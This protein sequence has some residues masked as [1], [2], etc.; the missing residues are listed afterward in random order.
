MKYKMIACDFD[1]TLSDS[2]SF[3]SEKNRQA[4]AEYVARGGKFVLSTGRMISAIIPHAKYLGLKGEVIGYQ[5]AVIADIE[6]GKFYNE[7]TIPYESA[8]KVARKLD[9]EG[10]YYQI[11][12]HDDYVI[13]AET[14][15]AEEYAKYTFEPPVIAGMPL[16][17]YIEKNGISPVKMLIITPPEKV[18]GYIDELSAEYGDEFLINTSK[19]FV[20]EIIRG[21]VNKA[22]AVAALAS[23]YGIKREEII[24]IGDSLN[25]V[26][27]VKYAGLGVMV[28]NA[29]DKAL[30]VADYVAPSCD[31]DGVA[32]VIE[33]IALKE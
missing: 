26:P 24:A 22:K 30:A 32:Y 23:K 29:S 1:D 20:V 4:I 16:S 11:Y 31:D 27:M 7:E 6:T 28:A 10:V 3:A 9:A 15:Y 19:K 2:T 5:G 14:E 13:P 21:D 17:E 18:D 8:L 25:D 12:V 33:N